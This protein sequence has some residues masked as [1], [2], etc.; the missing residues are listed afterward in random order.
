MKKPKYFTGSPDEIGERLQE[1]YDRMLKNTKDWAEI[2]AY[3]PFPQTGMT[4]KDTVWKKNKAKLHRY[5]SRNGLKHRIPVLFLYALINKA[6][7]L[8][9]TP[10]MS[11]IE[12]L[13]D[14]GYDVYLLEWGNFEWEDRN[15]SMADFVFDYIAHA[16]HKVCQFSGTDELSIIGYCMGGTMASMYASLFPFPKIKNLALLAAPLDFNNAGVTSYWL[17]Q[18]NFDTDKVVNTFELIP[19]TFLDFGVKMLNPVNNYV[20]TY[21]RLWKMIDEGLSVE[22]W[23][24]LNKWV[25]DNINFPGEAY[26]QWIKELYQEN[27][28]I[29][30]QFMLRGHQVDLS[31]IHSPLLVFYGKNDH[32]VLPHQSLAARDAIAS[33]DI[34]CMEFPIGHGGLVFGN[35]AKKHVYPSLSEWLNTRS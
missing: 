23:R 18:D 6:Y 21:T 13:V 12:Y 33:S 27:K 5:T 30:K 4:P 17:N 1:S 10:G 15:L 11:M 9:L 19:K 32:I 29:N 14:D 25:N 28:L 24:L 26:R 22:S 7:I 2:L 3:D 16:V 35:I 8:D 34:N 31:N 20:G